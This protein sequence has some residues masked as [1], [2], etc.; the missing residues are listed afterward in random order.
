MVKIEE[1]CM[2]DEHASSSP[3]DPDGQPSPHRNQHFLG[4]RARQ[5]SKD[6]FSALARWLKRGK[7]ARRGRGARQIQV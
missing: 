2:S 4:R 3:L 5:S 7:E 6:R 1:G